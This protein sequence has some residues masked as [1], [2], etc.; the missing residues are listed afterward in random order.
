MSMDSLERSIRP[1][2]NLTYSKPC[3]MEAF[4]YE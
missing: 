1:R 3:R 2:P 4:A